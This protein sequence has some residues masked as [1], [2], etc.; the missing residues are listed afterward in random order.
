MRGDPVN[1]LECPLLSTVCVQCIHVFPA[2][3]NVDLYE[4]E[5]VCMMDGLR[6]SSNSKHRKKWDQESPS[7]EMPI[8][9]PAV[10]QA[11]LPQYG[12]YLSLLQEKNRLLKHLR[13]K[14]KREV[15]KERKEKGFSIYINGANL[16]LPQQTG[17]HARPRVKT[18]AETR[19]P[20]VVKLQDLQKKEAEQT[21]RRVKTAPARERRR[22]WNLASV[23][24]NT[25]DGS[26]RL[27]AP[28]ILTGKYDDDFEVGSDDQDGDSDTDGVGDSLSSST[29]SLSTSRRQKVSYLKRL[30]AANR[31]V[32]ENTLTLT[33]DEVHKLRQSLQKNADIRK[34]MCLDIASDESEEECEEAIEEEEEIEEDLVPAADSGYLDDRG[35]P[36]RLFAPTDT[37]VLEFAPPADK[38]VEKKSL[39]LA[40]KK[41]SDSVLLSKSSSKPPAAAPSL[42][43]SSSSGAVEHSSQVQAKSRPTL[44]AGRR[45]TETRE[46]SKGEA[47]AVMK[48]MQEENQQAAHFA[49][50]S[51]PLPEPRKAS[52]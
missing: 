9:A 2:S 19:N 18:A 10:K 22:N 16:D 17:A 37:I 47:S 27:K 46:D 51:R 13:R 42:R 44:S 1:A 24:I 4:S 32:Q 26:K 48:A 43:K 21:K 40:R 39:M 36:P 15:D 11:V 50:Q 34:S 29:S 45:S 30:A 33:L 14:G 6:S 49:K 41:E 25:T 52:E 7:Q 5:D 35:K 28:E 3:Q 12:L 20:A 8:N 23:D 38:K 31:E